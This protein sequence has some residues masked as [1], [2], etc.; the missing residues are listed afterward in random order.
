MNSAFLYSLS[1]ARRILFLHRNRRRCIQWIHRV[2]LS[3]IIAWVLSPVSLPAQTNSWTSSADGNWQDSS[4]SLGV[5][6]GPG[7]TILITNAGSKTVTISAA[8]ASGFPQ[9][10]TVDSVTISSAPSFSNSL[11]LNS[12]GLNN[13]LNANSLTVRSNSAVVID[14]SALDVSNRITVAGTFT[15]DASS[16]VTNLSL[17][18]ESA[19]SGGY[20]L[21]GGLLVSGTGEDIGNSVPS[22]FTQNAGTNHSVGVRIYTNSIYQLNGGLLDGLVIVRPNGTFQQQGGLVDNSTNADD[23][24]SFDGTF[25]QSGGVFLGPTNGTMYFPAFQFLHQGTASG[26]G[27]QTGGT[28]VE[29]NLIVGLQ[30]PAENQDNGNVP[31]YGG[32]YTLSNGVLTTA[33]TIIGGNGAMEQAGGTHTI[34][35]A[36]SLQGALY[37]YNNLLNRSVPSA[38]TL[39]NGSLSSTG[40][41]IGVA[42]TFLQRG[43]ANQV[44]GDIH[45]TRSTDPIGYGAAG[46]YNLNNGQLSAS[47]IFVTGG[48]LN[49]AGGQLIIP[50][51]LQVTDG[52]FQQS[53]G[54]VTQSGLLTLADALWQ[55]AP[56]GQRLGP[57][58]V[59]ISGTVSSLLTMPSGACVLNLG[60]SSGITWSNAATLNIANWDGSI[61]GGGNQRIIFGSTSA[62]LTAQQLS[63]IS[64]ANPAGL[65][66]GNYPARILA[67]GEIV[68]NL[69]SNL[70]PSFTVVKSNAAVQIS[71][72]GQIGTSYVIQTSTN[73]TNW[74]NWTTQYDSTGTISISDS[75]TTGPVRFY[76]AVALP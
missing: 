23:I 29:G 4:W 30:L 22:A 21:N 61:Y 12:A 1:I 68:P 9:T 33:G 46:Q 31:A 28:N 48:Q 66:A 63:Q 34:D 18:A 41:S 15:Q 53:G 5:L 26:T 74:A 58:L 44:L 70:P 20:I 10:L 62:A 50:N 75:T 27:L 64:F 25:L 56:G 37:Y 36:L 6:P 13:P 65:S 73:L 67:T 40:I 42:A 76:R 60:D 38:Y 51:D 43:G 14:A 35:G 11:L 16:V 19:G 3:A 57:L 7:Q 55:S 2:A 17:D 39:D 72:G 49:Q 52:R 69:E 54:Q 59:G 32:T 8:T 47:N 45:L 71:L 24:A